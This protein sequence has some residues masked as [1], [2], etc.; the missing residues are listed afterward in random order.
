MTIVFPKNNLPEP[1]QPWAREVQKQLA[2]VIASNNSNEINNATRD[3]QLNS[4][5]ITISGVVSGVTT[6]LTEIGILESTVL[7]PGEPDKINGANIKVGTLSASTIT[8]GTMS[9]DRI[10]GGTINGVTFVTTGGVESINIST[11]RMNFFSGASLVGRIQ[12]ESGLLIIDNFQTGSGSGVAIGSISASLFG[13]G[14][15][16]TCGAVSPNII[17]FDG[18]NISLNSAGTLT[19]GNNLR[20]G[21]TLGRIQLDGDGSGTTGASFNSAGNLIR[22]TSSARYKLGIEDLNFDYS[23]ILSLRPRS[24]KLKSE[25]EGNL[26]EGQKPNKNAREYAGFIAEEI[27]GTPLDIFVSYIND[28]NGK[29]IPNGVYYQELTAALI[30]AI[31]HQD[32]LIKSLNDRITTLENGA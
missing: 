15:S 8:T 10:S 5:L 24:F 1:A 9:A 20:S 31:K 30:L 18:S 22:T 29:K 25:V 11:G 6:A 3:N 14:A 16:V 2:N 12:G 13:R 27:A 32:G 4:S 21:G 28:E 26:D 19:T 7:V 17:L 23:D